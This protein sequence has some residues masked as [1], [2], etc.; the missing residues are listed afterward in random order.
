MAR[1]A[2]GWGVR[3]LAEHAGVNKETVVRFELGEAVRADTA[4][5]LRQALAAEGVVFRG[6]TWVGA[7]AGDVSRTRRAVAIADGGHP[8]PRRLRTRT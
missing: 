5:L 2:L 6:D 7:P 1:A 4:E 8:K 3:D